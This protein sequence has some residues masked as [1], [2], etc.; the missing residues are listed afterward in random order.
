MV[1]NVNFKI[2]RTYCKAKSLSAL[3]EFNNQ[4]QTATKQRFLENALLYMQYKTNSRNILMHKYKYKY[5]KLVYLICEIGCCE[6]GAE[7]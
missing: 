3:L 6:K 7:N 4:G 5:S 2:D 1:G